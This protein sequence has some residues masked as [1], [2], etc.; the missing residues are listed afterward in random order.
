MKLKYLILLIFM[1]G[2]TACPTP[3]RILFKI[4]SFKAKIVVAEN[5]KLL[6]ENETIKWDDFAINL[7]FDTEE[8]LASN[9]VHLGNAAYAT[10]Y[11]YPTSKPQIN[12][13]VIY[14][15]NNQHVKT[16]MTGLFTLY[17]N[18]EEFSGD[19]ISCLNTMATESF[20][21]NFTRN[22][23]KLEQDIA[24]DIVGRFY[25]ELGFVD[26]SVLQDSTQTV[27]ITSK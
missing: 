27:T 2:L 9:F 11:A 15:K 16:N 18:K 1:F 4:N 14:H 23:L 19:T 8:L 24:D 6:K 5:E 3:D 10:R 7:Y 20:D 13:L 12:S 25:I 21:Q 22:Y 17:F 26:G